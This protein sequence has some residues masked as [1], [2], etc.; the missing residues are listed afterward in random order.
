MENIYYWLW[1][2]FSKSESKK[3]K[4]YTK[5]YAGALVFSCLLGNFILLVSCIFLVKRDVFV[6]LFAS[7]MLSTTLT[8]LSIIILFL[9]LFCFLFLSCRTNA[10]V[11][12]FSQLSKKSRTKKQFIYRLYIGLTIFTTIL[13]LL[14]LLLK[15]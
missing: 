5:E 13:I 3:Q 8:Y 1:L 11:R 14:F 4:S 6:Y 15:K 2:Q 7:S 12:K 10:I 9:L